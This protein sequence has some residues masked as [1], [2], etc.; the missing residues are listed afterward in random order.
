MLP[1]DLAAFF[2]DFR[3]LAPRTPLNAFSEFSA[4]VGPRRPVR[5]VDFGECNT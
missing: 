3:F 5:L 2:D 1:N 4:I